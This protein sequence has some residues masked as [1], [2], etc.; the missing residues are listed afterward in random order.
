MGTSNVTVTTEINS[1]RWHLTVDGKAWCRQSEEVKN[2]VM[3]AYGDGRLTEPPRCQYSRESRA[4]AGALGLQV[5]LG[6][7]VKV[8]VVE[9]RCEG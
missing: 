6:D 5:V 8:E 2:K 4:I 7:G 9:G 1:V 3:D